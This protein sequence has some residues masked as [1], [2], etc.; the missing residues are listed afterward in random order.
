MAMTAESG[1]GTSPD[2]KQ[3]VAAAAMYFQATFFLSPILTIW[4]AI[5]ASEYIVGNNSRV[6]STSSLSPKGSIF[7]LLLFKGLAATSIM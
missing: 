3:V 1:I 6:L 2:T 4:L 5:M 7:L